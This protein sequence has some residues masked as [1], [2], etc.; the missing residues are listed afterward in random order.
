MTFETELEKFCSRISSIKEKLNTE[1]STKNGLIMPLLNI[2]GYNVFDPDEVNPE[3]TADFGTKTKEKVD[4]AIIKNGEPIMLVECKPCNQKLGDRQASQLYRYFSVCP[5]KIGILTNGLIYKFY[6][7]L[8]EE[9]KMDKRP[10]LTLDLESMNDDEIQKLSKFQK[11]Q[12]DSESIVTQG[13]KFRI[14][15]DIV[16]II[17]KE[18][19]NPSDELVKMISKPIH[20][21][22]MNQKAID[23]YRPLIKAAFSQ[24]VA[25]RLS[26]KV[27]A[28]QT[29][30]DD[31]V[32]ETPETEETK[33]PITT[34]E[35][36]MGYNIVKAIA[37]QICP[38]DRV[39]IRDAMSYCAILFDNNNR[40]PITRLHF[41]SATSKY[42]ST[43]DADGKEVKHKV[44]GPQD[45]YNLQKEILDTIKTYLE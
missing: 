5:A 22:L 30:I 29:S 8:D 31:D 1:E 41:N 23:K 12:F 42:I 3:Y 13:Q 6:S 39:F 20:E 26:I 27:Q 14:M 37:S 19:D 11:D 2:L 33:G 4:Y 28:L 21:G 7:D 36:I 45:L 43:F 25:D 9:N 18:M 24:I 35:E 17:S 16:S 44:S 10:F 34:E 38:I 40:K 15:D 32:V